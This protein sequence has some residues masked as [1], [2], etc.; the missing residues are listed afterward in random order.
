ML[1]V[2]SAQDFN[3]A[4]QRLKY[5]RQYNSYRKKQAELIILTQE[6]IQKRLNESLAKKARKEDLLAGQAEQL[7]EYESARERKQKVVNSLAQNEKKLKRELAAKQ[8]A[9]KKL[10]QMIQAAIRREIERAEA[11]ARKKGVTVGDKPLLNSAEKMR[12]ND[13]FENSK[14]SLPWPVDHGFIS[15]H[16]G[17]N[18]HPVLKN[19]K[20]FN[21]GVDLSCNNGEV[22]KAVFDGEVAKIIS[23][24]GMQK[25]VLISHGNYFTVYAH[26]DNVQVKMGEI[27]AARQPLAIIYTDVANH[28]T[29]MHFEI[30]QGKSKMNP[31]LWLRK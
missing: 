21:N 28:K 26:L 31:E 8:K 13:G 30:W 12:L 16:Y 24:P 22:V 29:E 6:D 25:I 5:I 19:I 17:E 27:I 2:L 9:R 20:T 1:F 4:Y 7:I 3:Q 15:E 14:G 11:E 23:L 18:Q 10:D